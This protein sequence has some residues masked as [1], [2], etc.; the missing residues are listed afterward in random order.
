MIQDT[1]K[2]QET[3]ERRTFLLGLFLN[4]MIRTR[5]PGHDPR[6]DHASLNLPRL[7][8]FVIFFQ[9]FQLLCFRSRSRSPITR[10]PWSVLN[11]LVR[12]NNFFNAT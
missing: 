3:N 6:I 11:D 2:F 7:L 12:T 4:V 8:V 5:I 9:V 1:R 10:F